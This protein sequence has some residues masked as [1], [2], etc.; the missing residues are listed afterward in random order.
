MPN[1]GNEPGNA[2]HEHGQTV[3]QIFVDG[4]EITTQKGTISVGDLKALAG[5]PPAYE[6]E[7]VREKR[8]IP[9]K[10]DGRV[11]LKDKEHFI[12]HPRDGVSS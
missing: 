8:L 11:E 7:E 3:I 5:V 4:K 12:S 1:L 10:D 2:G 6:L 9:L